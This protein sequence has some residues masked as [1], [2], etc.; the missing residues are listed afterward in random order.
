MILVFS[1]SFA[2][3]SEMQRL[4]L[5]LVLVGVV[6]SQNYLDEDDSA[7]TNCPCGWG[8][9]G[10]IVGGRES[11]ANAYPFMAALTFTDG[12]PFCGATI[13]TRRHA[14]T[15]AHCTADIKDKIKELRLLV[16]AHDIRNAVR[17]QYIPVARTI[18]HPNYDAEDNEAHDIAMIVLDR[19]LIY[20]NDVGP[21]CLP[22]RRVNLENS[23]L[24]VAG[25]GLT[26]HEGR[27]SKVLREVIL[28][29]IPWATC[30]RFYPGELQIPRT[31]ICTY[32]KNKDSCQG[33]SG[34]PL[35]AVDPK[36]SKF[37]IV[38]TVSF[39]RDCASEN[40]AVNTDIGHY[41]NWIKS[42]VKET[43]N[44]SMETCSRIS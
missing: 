41:L 33:D 38:A 15:A 9:K 24:L 42:V 44:G 43:S 26:K 39:G 32:E 22:N 37:V 17:D 5:G 14:I 8:V 23:H 30:H 4:L 29:V 34:G 2:E 19:N 1:R 40:P 3:I 16:G 35:I 36:I 7:A 10:R 27:T 25:W 31:Q 20:R 13:L 21:A 18:E 11:R 6:S 28:R 12:Q